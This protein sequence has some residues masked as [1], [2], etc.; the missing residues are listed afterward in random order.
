MASADFPPEGS[1]GI[2]PGKNAVLRRAAT[3][4]TSR[5][6]SNGFAVLCQLTRPGRPC[7]GFLFIRSRLLPSLPSDGRLPS[8]P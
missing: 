5:V 3:S 1:G 4:F 7:M 6:E 2:S 8:R